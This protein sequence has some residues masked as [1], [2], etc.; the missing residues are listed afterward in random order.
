MHRSRVK[1]KGW[2]YFKSHVS[3][4]CQIE[5]IRNKN[6]SLKWSHIKCH[7][8]VLS[9]GRST[10]KVVLIEKRKREKGG[11][12]TCFKHVESCSSFFV[13][14][15]REVRWMCSC[16]TS[17]CSLDLVSCQ[18]CSAVSKKILTLIRLQKMF[19][20]LPSLFL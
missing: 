9:W 8:A 14:K 16:M 10:K 6:S 13:L 1:V 7:H 5:C 11:F 18:D 20:V 4:L 19:P 2:K 3:V 17:F 15:K 12:L